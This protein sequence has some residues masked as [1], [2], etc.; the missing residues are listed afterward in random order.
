MQCFQL[1][2]D[3]ARTLVQRTRFFRDQSGTQVKLCTLKIGCDEENL[4]RPALSS[5]YVITWSEYL[6]Y[7]I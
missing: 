4:P 5:T 7:W 3:W 2:L 1:F 6:T